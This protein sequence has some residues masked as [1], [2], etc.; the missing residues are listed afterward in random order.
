MNKYRVELSDEFKKIWCVMLRSKQAAEPAASVFEGLARVNQLTSEHIKEMYGESAIEKDG[1][2]FT[3]HCVPS[4]DFPQTAAERR[5]KLK[6]GR[7]DERAEISYAPYAETVKALAEFE[8]MKIRKGYTGE[9]WTA[10]VEAWKTR[11]PEK[12]LDLCEE[13]RVERKM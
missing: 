9:Q 7:D 6:A 8:A 2:F 12:A 13:I 5:R 10:K 1:R 4:K 11:N 3:P